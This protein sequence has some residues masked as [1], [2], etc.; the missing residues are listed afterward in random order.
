MKLPFTAIVNICVLNETKS[1]KYNS[2]ATDLERY[3]T[4]PMPGGIKGVRVK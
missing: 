2:V 1:L 3:S 4:A